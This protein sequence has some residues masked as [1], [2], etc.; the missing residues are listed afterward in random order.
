[1]RP[2]F[3]MKFVAL[4][5]L[6]ALAS[7]SNASAA[8]TCSALEDKCLRMVAKA[9]DKSAK[10]NM[11]PDHFFPSDSVCFQAYDQAEASGVWPG[12]GPMLKVNCTR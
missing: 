8:Q 10:Q 5:L 12:I 7:A 3:K 1:M 9:A 2:R 6:C 11:P 4:G